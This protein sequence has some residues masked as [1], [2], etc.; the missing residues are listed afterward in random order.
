MSNDELMEPQRA[1]QDAGAVTTV[2]SSTSRKPDDIPAFN[3]EMIK[4][5]G[6]HK[7]QRA[8]AA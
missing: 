5:F 1:L 2:V 7:S 8:D 6:R 3:Q 4:L